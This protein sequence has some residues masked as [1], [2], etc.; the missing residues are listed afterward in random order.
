[1]E[2]EL[3]SLLKKYRNKKTHSE[4]PNS[5]ENNLLSSVVT[6]SELEE[7]Q[8]LI[9]DTI[10]YELEKI[11]QYQIITH[12]IKSGSNIICY[13]KLSDLIYVSM[14]KATNEERKMLEIPY[15]ILQKIL[16]ILTD[17]T[18]LTKEIFEEIEKDLDDANEIIYSE[19]YMNFLLQQPY[20]KEILDFLDKINKTEDEC[21]IYNSCLEFK[22]II[23]N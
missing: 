21:E 22:K 23:S 6:D 14:N 8:K 2:I 11:D 10:N 17:D 15:S 3:I 12:N 19:E 9:I 16:N 13:K 5:L 20:G 7:L 4:N 18:L 1:M